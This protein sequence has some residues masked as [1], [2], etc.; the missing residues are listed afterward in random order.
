MG[1]LSY[2]SWVLAISV[3]GALLRRCEAGTCVDPRVPGPRLLAL[4][5]YGA[6]FS[7]PLTIHHP[8]TAISEK[9]PADPSGSPDDEPLG[10]EGI[11]G[12]Q[13]EHP[14]D[15]S[16]CLPPVQKVRMTLMNG[17]NDV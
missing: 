6:A 8:P 14:N 5:L 13:G 15:Q 7:S 2:L 17:H 10:D 3:S 9:L 12:K 11:L 16:E 4:L 1:R